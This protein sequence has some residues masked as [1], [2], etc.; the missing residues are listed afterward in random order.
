M[1][2]DKILEELTSV[3]RSLGF[4]VRREAGSFRG[5]YCLLNDKKLI[6][7]NRSMP[8]E[9]AGVVLARA[10]SSF[11]VDSTY[12]KPAVRDLLDRERSVVRAEQTVE[13]DI[14]SKNE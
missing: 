3:A 8:L 5:G 13:F 7:I 14:A 6:I 9:G 12:L 1:K 10:L 2:A 11:D 4:S